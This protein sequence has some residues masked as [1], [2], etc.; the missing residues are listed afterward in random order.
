MTVSS[1]TGKETFE[2]EPLWAP[3]SHQAMNWPGVM[4]LWLLAGV[5][6]LVG[7]VAGLAVLVLGWLLFPWLR[8]RYLRQRARHPV[9]A[10]TLQGQYQV[11]QETSV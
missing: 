6:M 3:I 4:L 2:H 8:Y 11:H 7:Y 1:R 5:L 10:Q 9:Q